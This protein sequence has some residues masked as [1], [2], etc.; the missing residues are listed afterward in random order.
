MT[1]PYQKLFL[2][3]QKVGRGLTKLRSFRLRW[4]REIPKRFTRNERLSFIGLLLVLLFTLTLNANR[5]YKNHTVEKPARGSKYTEGLVGEP[6]YI[7]P[8]LATTQTDKDLSRLIFSGLYKLDAEGHLSPDLADG[9]VQISPDGKQ[10]T[11]KIK[12]NLKWHDGQPITADDVVFT[13]QLLQNQDYKSPYRNLWQNIQVQRIDDLQIKISNPNISAPFLTNLTLGILPRHIWANVSG[14]DFQFSTMN[15]EPIGSGPF[16]AKEINKLSNGSISSVDL[17]SYSNYWGGKPYLDEIE[18]KF[19]H[20]NDELLYAMQTKNIQGIGFVPIDK[21]IFVDEKSTKQT[22]IKIPLYEYQALFF[23]LSKSK[24]LGDKNVRQALAQSVDRNAF[25]N[26]VF[27]GLGS[28]AYTP[29]MAG[30][31]GYNA[32]AANINPFGVDQANSLLD[33]AGWVKDPQTGFRSKGK[34]QLAF[35]IT[36]NDFILNSKSADELKEQWKKI[37]VNVTV[38]VVPSADIEKAVIRP[39]N[40]E[41]LLFSETTGSDPDPFVF[42]HSSQSQD[43]GINISQYKNTTIDRLIVDARNTFDN[44]ARIDKYRQ[45]QEIFSLDIP[46]IILDQSDFVYEVNPQIKGIK[47]KALANPEDRFY[48]AVN[49]YIQTSRSWK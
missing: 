9:D 42:W 21:K 30:Q 24:V 8:L 40:F 23:N 4:L 20:N 46:A 35:T 48:D 6:R 7:N 28:P 16:L 38:S 1:L 13:I 14:S 18:L 39:R 29:I 15:L 41:T 19:Y 47:I 22:V 5:F 2:E 17:Q 43:P 32:D 36:T 27:S 25:I 44:N 12:P 3:I 10:Y 26:N 49:W 34:D 37:G 11:I 31:I 45:F 33:K